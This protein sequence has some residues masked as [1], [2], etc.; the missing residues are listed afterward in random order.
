VPMETWSRD[1]GLFL[2]A[3]TRPG[4]KLPHAWL[5]DRHGHKIS[6]L[7]VVGR[8]RFTAVTGL[9][10]GVWA[11]AVVKL[12]LPF[13]RVVVI[14][15]PGF[16]DSYGDWARQREVEESGVLLARP[17]GYI[18]WR[19]QVAVVNVTAAMDRLLAAIGSILAHRASAD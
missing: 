5:V 7:D 2:Q 17:D 6:T 11:D 16:V 9:S 14:G 4:A 3:S 15:A 10:G 18:G 19:E 12:D 13:L 1:R 8:G